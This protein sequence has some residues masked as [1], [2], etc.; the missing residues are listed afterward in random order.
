MNFGLQ[1]KDIVSFWLLINSKYALFS[2]CFVFLLQMSFL[3]SVEVKGLDSSL[4]F[5]QDYQLVGC[6]F[7][8]ELNSILPLSKEE[9]KFP[10]PVIYFKQCNGVEPSI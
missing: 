4:T 1:V 7:C 9:R 10:F 6:D 3:H 8:S 2:H 5:T